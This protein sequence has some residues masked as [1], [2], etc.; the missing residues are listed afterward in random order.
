MHTCAYIVCRISIRFVKGGAFT[1][2]R[3][4]FSRE[5]VAGETIITDYTITEFLNG[6]IYK[7]LSMILC[8]KGD[9]KLQDYKLQSFRRDK[10]ISFFLRFCVM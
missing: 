4:I 5:D 2:I 9:D 3:V 7:L 10:L 6:Q 8:D 1:R